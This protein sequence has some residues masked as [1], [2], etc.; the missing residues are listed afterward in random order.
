MA[1]ASNGVTVTTGGSTLFSSNQNGGTDGPGMM[2]FRVQ[3]LSGICRV[4]APPLLPVSL[5]GTLLSGTIL[6]GANSQNNS[7]SPV[8]NIYGSFTSVVVKGVGAS[9]K[10]SFR[11]EMGER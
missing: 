7:W 4:W 9:A 11:P 6:S 2:A 1:R 3:C 10:V 5:A 8:G